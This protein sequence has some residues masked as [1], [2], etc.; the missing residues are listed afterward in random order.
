MSRLI[1]AATAGRIPEQFVQ[2]GRLALI[3]RNKQQLKRVILQGET[4]KGNII[5]VRWRGCKEAYQLL[6][7]RNSSHPIDR[8]A[9]AR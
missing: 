8:Q 1:T 6:A 3:R 7:G 5:Q 4:K 2:C 9:T